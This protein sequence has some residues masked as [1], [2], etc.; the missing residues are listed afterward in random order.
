[1]AK[2]AELGANNAEALEYYNRVL[3][4]DPAITEAWLGKGRSASWQ[5]SL[6]TFRVAEGLIAFQHAIATAGENRDAVIQTAVEEINKI[7]SALYAMSRNHMEE[8]AAL[9]QT[10]SSYINQ[11]A[12][13][14]EALEQAH[15]WDPSNRIVLENIVH[16]TKDNIEGYKYWD[17]IHNVSGV[18]AISP[19]YEET[20]RGI[21]DRAV[22]SLRQIDD[23]Y[24]PPAIEKK[25]GGACFVVTAAMGDASHPDVIALRNFRDRWLLK[26]PVGRV[27]ISWYYR[28]GP[29]LAAFVGRSPLRRRIA[30]FLLVRPAVTVTSRRLR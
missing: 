21:M 16:L 7:I 26:R 19:Q 17:N 14:L 2:T 5:S 27:A 4:I 25:Q 23:A 28:F 8:Y 22:A 29:T 1:M 9:D 30:Y 15:D 18:H 6:A 20:L 3:E 11:T 12:Q 10:W 13:M 24:Q